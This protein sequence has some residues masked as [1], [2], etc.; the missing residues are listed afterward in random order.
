MSEPGVGLRVIQ[1]LD[2][3]EILVPGIEITHERLVEAEQPKPK[4]SQREIV[5]LVCDGQCLSARRLRRLV[6]PAH[7]Q[8]R[9][10]AEEGNG[11]SR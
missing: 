11:G 10:E 2:G 3:L 4:D 9:R 6:Q 1:A 7:T 5:Q 8:H